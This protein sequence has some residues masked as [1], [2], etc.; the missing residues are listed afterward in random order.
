[1]S[2]E[3]KVSAIVVNWN[4]MEFLPTCLDSIFKQTYKNLEVI[5]VDCASKDES[6][7]WTTKNYPK[8]KII[9]LQKDPGPPAAINLAAR[10]AEGDYILILNNDVILPED[11]VSRLAKEMKKDENCVVTAAELD[12]ERRYVKS[13]CI[14]PWISP[15]LSKFIKIKGDTTFFSTTA[16]C[17]ISKKL[18][19]ENPLNEKLFLYEDTEWGWRLQLKQIKTK[20]LPDIGFIHKGQGTVSKSKRLAFVLGRVP[21]A[22]QFICFRFLTFLAFLPLTIIRYYL[23]PI[24]VLR[25]L[26]N[27]PICLFYFY[28]GFLGFLVNFYRY[29]PERKKVQAERKAGDSQILKIMI[30]SIY[31]KKQ[32]KKEWLGRNQIQRGNIDEPETVG[33]LSN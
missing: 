12:W 9:F 2:G 31:Y 1:L 10:Q 17:L 15:F 13:G 3:K 6:V 30:G 4:G 26:K 14:E 19:L 20:I 7:S 27:S 24:T 5:V 11:L 18:L 32:A 29:L 33:C 22:T 21:I 28:K 23:S 16:C 8:A 25:Y